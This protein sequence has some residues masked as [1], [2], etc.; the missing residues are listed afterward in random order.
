MGDRGDLR[1]VDFENSRRFQLREAS[2]LNGRGDREREFRLGEPRP[3]VG[4]TEIGEDIA[5]AFGET[6]LRSHCSILFLVR[7]RV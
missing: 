6:A 4:Q 1:L 2:V 5:Q 7:Q 3:R